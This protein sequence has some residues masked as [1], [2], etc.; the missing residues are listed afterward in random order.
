M[1]ILVKLKE[2]DTMESFLRIFKYKSK[3]KGKQLKTTH[4]HDNSIYKKVTE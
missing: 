1:L 2:W 4:W 3:N